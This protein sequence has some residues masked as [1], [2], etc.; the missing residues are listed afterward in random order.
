MVTFFFQ[1]WGVS[2]LLASFLGIARLLLQFTRGFG[3][4]RQ[5]RFG[6][7]DPDRAELLHIPELH[8]ERPRFAQ[9]KMLKKRMLPRLRVNA[10]V[11]THSV[12][13]SR[14]MRMHDAFVRTLVRVPAYT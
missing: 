14:R 5:H 2:F 10:F 11:L 4:L 3:S 12:H 8:Q 1:L 7:C 6:P 9:N 13:V